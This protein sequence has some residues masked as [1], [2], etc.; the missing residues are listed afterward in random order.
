MKPPGRHSLPP[1]PQAQGSE[2][3]F[4]D[5]EEKLKTKVGM[6]CERTLLVEEADIRL[7]S[8]E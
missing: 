1:R 5:V 3:F 8:F 4:R 2:V 6:V 7:N